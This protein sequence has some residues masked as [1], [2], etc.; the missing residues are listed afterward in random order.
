[1]IDKTIYDKLK[2]EAENLD[3]ALASYIKSNIEKWSKH[4]KNR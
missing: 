3:I 1:M 4:G 2:Q